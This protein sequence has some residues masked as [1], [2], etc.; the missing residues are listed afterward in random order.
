MEKTDSVKKLATR[1]RIP[2]SILDIE[3]PIYPRVVERVFRSFLVTI[4][5]KGRENDAWLIPNGMFVVLWQCNTSLGHHR[6]EYGV[7][8]Q[9]VWWK[10]IRTRLALSTLRS[11]G[12]HPRQTIKNVLSLI[13]YDGGWGGH[14]WLESYDSKFYSYSST[15][16]LVQKS[17]VILGYKSNW[18]S[19]RKRIF[20]RT[21]TNYMIA[22]QERFWK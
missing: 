16:L 6:F 9:F 20:S 14:L 2:L 7:P 21:L 17:D 19:V 10:S 11:N 4:V 1:T 3:N 13:S 5:C 18:F 8:H 15:R 22:K 12:N